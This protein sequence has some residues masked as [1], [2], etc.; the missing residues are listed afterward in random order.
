[1][2]RFHDE[3]LRKNDTTSGNSY[4]APNFP[5]LVILPYGWLQPIPLTAC[6]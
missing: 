4:H 1:M 5:H 3:F 2:R 6:P